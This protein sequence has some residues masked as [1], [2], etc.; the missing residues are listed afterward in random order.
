MKYDISDQTGQFPKRSI[1]G[2]KYIM[3]PV[4]IDSDTIMVKPTKSRK[5]GEMIRAY[6]AMML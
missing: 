5:D 6:L 2:T 1:H 3:V 4:E